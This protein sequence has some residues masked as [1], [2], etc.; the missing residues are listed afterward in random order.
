MLEGLH[1]ILLLTKNPSED[2]ERTDDVKGLSLTSY[3]V[4]VC[5]ILSR[6]L[7]PSPWWLLVVKRMGTFLSL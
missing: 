1:F 3:L 2:E 4:N 6:Q 7:W 5:C